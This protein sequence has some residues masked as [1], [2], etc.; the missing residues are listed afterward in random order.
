MGKHSNFP[1]SSLRRSLPPGTSAPKVELIA[2][3]RPLELWIGKILNVYTDS[4]CVCYLTGTRG[5]LGGERYACCREE[6]GATWLNHTEDLRS[7]TASKI[8][9][10]DS[11]QGSPKGTRRDNPGKQQ[12]RH[13]SQKCGFRTRNSATTPYTW[14]AGFIQLFPTL[15]KGRIRQ[16]PQMGLQQRPRRPRVAG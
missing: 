2:C 13:N 7:T 12:G 6:A 11:L 16:S 10:S 9:V 8:G 3:I 5:Y 14:K 1:D 4:W 15:P